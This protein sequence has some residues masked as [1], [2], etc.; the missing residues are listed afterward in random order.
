MKK[1]GASISFQLVDIFNI[2]ENA[3]LSIDEKKIRINEYQK[4]LTQDEKGIPLT[5]KNGQN[6]KEGFFVFRKY[7]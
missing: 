3:D 7:R 5:T 4:S 2:I 1:I 6:E